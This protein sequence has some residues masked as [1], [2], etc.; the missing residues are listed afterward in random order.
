[1]FELEKSFH[2]EAGHALCHHDGKCRRPHGHSYIL[3]VQLQADELIKDGPK[4]NMVMDFNDLTEIVKKMI[5]S[6]FD[7]HWLNEKLQSDSPTA[8]FIA[9]WI[10]HHL[11]PQIPLLTAVSLHETA[12]SKVTYRPG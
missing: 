10:Y 5:N 3:T 7:H 8:E 4:R 2:F 11:K 12:T 1:M 6:Y 9:Q